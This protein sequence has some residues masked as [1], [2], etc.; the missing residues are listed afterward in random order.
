MLLWKAGGSFP[1]YRGLADTQAPD[2]TWHVQQ[3]LGMPVGLPEVSV[4][5]KGLTEIDSTDWNPKV[6]VPHW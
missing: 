4:L 5:G 2:C 6:W 1:L 3:A